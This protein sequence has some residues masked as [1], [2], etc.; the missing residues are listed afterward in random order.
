MSPADDTIRPYAP[1][2][3]GV[4]QAAAW[5]VPAIT[6]ATAAPA[7]AIST[8]PKPPLSFSSGLFWRPVE[9]EAPAE[10]L[11]YWNILPQGIVWITQV[12]NLGTAALPDVKLDLAVPGT[13]G[14]RVLAATDVSNT[15]V[16]VSPTPSFLMDSPLVRPTSN[17]LL[18]TLPSLPAS[19]SVNVT[20]VIQRPTTV[21]RLSTPTWAM[22][23]I[24]G[25]G[26][27]LSTSVT[28]TNYA[29]FL[30]AVTP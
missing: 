10:E 24:P 3:R 11:A 19:T 30:G 29:T 16:T 5:S 23:V 27:P 28:V 9:G 13:G 21:P 12:T 20:V 25:S 1:S 8:A 6:L 4:V 7:F 14:F 26:T 22:N 17:R 2:R 15:D 18:V